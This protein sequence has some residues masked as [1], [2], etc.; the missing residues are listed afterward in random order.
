MDFGAEWCGPCRIMDREV[1]TDPEVMKL[2][3]RFEMLRV[4]LTRTHPD[5]KQVLEKYAIKGVPTV[6]FLNREGVELKHLRIE[7]IVSKTDFLN[8]M[9]AV[10]EP[11][12]GGKGLRGDPMARESKP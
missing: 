5:Q 3:R 1:F 9:R 4:D 12:K 6:I 10:L 2:S 11:K 7:C 8:R